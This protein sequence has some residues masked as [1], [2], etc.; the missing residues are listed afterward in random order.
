MWLS[1]VLLDLDTAQNLLLYKSNQISD[2]EHNIANENS[3][4]FFSIGEMDKLPTKIY[5]E[6]K[7]S[8]ETWQCLLQTFPRNALIKFLP[9]PI[10][11]EMARC[12]QKDAKELDKTLQ[13][14]SYYSS[15][16]LRPLDNAIHTLYQTKP[17]KQNK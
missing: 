6:N 8:T 1:L 3:T 10:D 15:S 2:D 16:I 9:P 14:V 7:L 12:M 17:D 13:H 5:K 11:K 4:S